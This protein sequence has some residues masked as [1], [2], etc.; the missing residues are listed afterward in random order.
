MSL[1]TLFTQIILSEQ[2]LSEQT[3]KT[4]GVNVAISSCCEQITSLNERY[5]RAGEA[6]DRTAQ[7]L[8]EMKLQHNLMKKCHNDLLR[9]SEELLCQKKHLSGCLASIKSERQEEGERF[10]GEVSSFNR[11]F[12]LRGNTEL[13]FQNQIHTDL[14]DLDREAESLRREMELISCTNSHISGVQE[15]K[16]ALQVELQQLGGGQ[17]DLDQQLREAEATTASLRA[18]RRLVSRKPATDSKC[19]RLRKE[20][21]M[22]QEAELELLREALSSEI[23][24]VKSKLDSSRRRQQN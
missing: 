1:D 19:L 24:S 5:G 17:E 12:S 3:Q 11:D 21:E 13:V 10:S 6:L 8:S 4:K 20:L 22:H 9:E 15:E 14:L 7:Q 23:Q 16:R 2:Q 18:E